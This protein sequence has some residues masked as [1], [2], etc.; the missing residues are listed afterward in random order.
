MAEPRSNRERSGARKILF[1][2]IGDEAAFCFAERC[3]NRLAT[4][5]RAAVQRRASFHIAAGDGAAL[6]K[7]LDQTPAALCARKV[8]EGAATPC[9]SRVRVLAIQAEPSRHLMPP[10]LPRLLNQRK[11]ERDVIILLLIPFGVG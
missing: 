9:V 6:E 5:L 3:R 11:A 4:V 10:T 2:N 8:E 7:L 1:V